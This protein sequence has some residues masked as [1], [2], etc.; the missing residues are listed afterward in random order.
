MRAERGPENTPD[1]AAPADDALSSDK[2]L[3]TTGVANPVDALQNS[4][5]RFNNSAGRYQAQL[6]QARM[7]RG[8]SAYREQQ[9]QPEREYAASVLAGLDVYA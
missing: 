4:A 5:R 2:S 8:I 3:S 7:D 1:D 6:Q 9:V